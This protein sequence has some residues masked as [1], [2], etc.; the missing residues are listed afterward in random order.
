MTDEP[1]SKVKIEDLPEEQ[2]GLS[3]EEAKEVQ[4][5]AIAGIVASSEYFNRNSAQQPAGPAKGEDAASANRNV[6][7]GYTIEN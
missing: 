3:P 2:K 6:V 4:G 5:G 7:Q 1:K